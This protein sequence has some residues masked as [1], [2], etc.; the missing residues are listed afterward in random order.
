M[1]Q[2]QQGTFPRVLSPFSPGF[3]PSF[4]VG[5][6]KREQEIIDGSLKSPF[7]HTAYLQSSPEQA[8]GVGLRTRASHQN[9]GPGTEKSTQRRA[10]QTRGSAAWT[11]LS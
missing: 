10:V 5:G 7:P 6:A 1:R 8:A 4:T 11:A 2:A 3:P 9:Q